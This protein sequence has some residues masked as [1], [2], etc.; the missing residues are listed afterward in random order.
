[1]K[2]SVASLPP[3]WD[4]RWK[5]VGRKPYDSKA[6]TV[7]TLWQEMEGKPERAYTADLERDREHLKLLGL[8][9]APH[10]TSLYRTRRR[11]TDDYMRRLNQRIR[12]RIKGSRRFGVDAT[13]LHQSSC[14]GA[15]SNARQ[16]D[17][18]GYVKLHALFDLETSA[19]KE[20][21]ATLGTRHES[22]VLARLLADIEAF[23]TDP[24]YLSRRKLRL[25]AD[26]GGTPYIKPKKNSIIRARGCWPWRQ[27]VDLYRRHPRLFQR[28][29]RLRPR[30][31]SWWHSLKSLVGDLVRSRTIQ[32][33]KTEI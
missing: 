10:R 2:W 7:V 24:G 31:E 22:P 27:M 23:V 21:E 32:T 11:L 33:I 9:R 1:L 17:K 3:P 16:G 5:G 29:Y 14:K 18:R 25:V 26:R 13:G 15:W 28:L 6:L 20:V 8:D 19:I 30:M 4:S 12:E